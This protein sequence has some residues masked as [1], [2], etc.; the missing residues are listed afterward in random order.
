MV[1][2]V[3]VQNFET[4]C[5]NSAASMVQWW[6]R[7][8]CSSSVASFEDR[9]CQHAGYDRMFGAISLA[10]LQYNAVI[11]TLDV[12]FICP[13][14]VIDP[15]DLGATTVVAPGRMNNKFLLIPGAESLPLYRSVFKLACVC[16]VCMCVCDTI[17]NITDRIKC[18]ISQCTMFY[19]IIYGIICLSHMIS[20][21]IS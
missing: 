12:G 7:R 18:M 9:I 20:Y 15:N 11:L 10:V 4:R 8:Y 16:I 5:S 14:V 17:H 21:M 2:F 6:V 13:F 19:V 3:S 1:I